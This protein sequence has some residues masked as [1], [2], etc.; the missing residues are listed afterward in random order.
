MEGI[1][2]PLLNLLIN[3]RI[4]LAAL[5][6]VVTVVAVSA[7][8]AGRALA[9]AASSVVVPGHSFPVPSQGAGSGHTSLVGVVV[10]AALVAATVAFGVIG[11]RYDRRR[12]AHSRIAGPEVA[13]TVATDAAQ[14]ANEPGASGPA[15]SKPLPT[16]TAIAARARREEGEQAAVTGDRDHEPMI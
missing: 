9:R 7:L 12:I 13:E 3:P 5:A 6:S 15:A 2:K 16:R 11:W 4:A 8:T 1:M 14:P 10:V